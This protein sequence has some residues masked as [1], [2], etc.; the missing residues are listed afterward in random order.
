M[1]ENKTY[2]WKEYIEDEYIIFKTLQGDMGVTIGY[3]DIE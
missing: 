2:S 1:E 3:K